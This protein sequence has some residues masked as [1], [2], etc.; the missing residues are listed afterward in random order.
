V[1]TKWWRSWL[2]VLAA[3]ACVAPT[4]GNGLLDR[5]DSGYVLENENI[6][7]LSFD[8]VRWALTGSGCKDK[9]P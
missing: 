1:S 6:R 4:P 2:V 9:R 7:T 8:T 3:F 5:D